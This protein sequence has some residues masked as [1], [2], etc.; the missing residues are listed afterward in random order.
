MIDD[1]VFEDAGEPGAQGRLAGEAVR[2]F[3]RGEQRFLNGVFGRRIAQLQPR[4]N[5]TGSRVR[6]R[7]AA[8]SR[9]RL[10]PI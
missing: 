3:D 8:W 6:A 1:L 9:G 4:V 10:G 7:S 2:P 5:A